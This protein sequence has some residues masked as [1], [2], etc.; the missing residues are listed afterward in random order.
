M[1]L[2]FAKKGT[3]SIDF[4]DGATIE[5]VTDI[6]KR[7]FNALI[8]AMPQDLDPDKGFTPVQGTQF[9]EALFSSLVV[10][11]TLKDE[12]GADVPATVE[13]YLALDQ[14]SAQRVDE[15]LVA[16]FGELSVGVSDQ[17]KQETSPQI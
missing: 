11:W 6:S 3:K 10:S 14:E 7:D 12:S 13:S 4:G 16:H 15:K 1:G 8:A 5:V 9:Q 17:K 2:R